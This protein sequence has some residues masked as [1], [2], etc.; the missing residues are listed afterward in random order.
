[1]VEDSDADAV[2]GQEVRRH[3]EESLLGE[4]MPRQG[5]SEAAG[6]VAEF[7]ALGLMDV[8]ITEVEQVFVCFPCFIARR[9]VT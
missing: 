4:L 3:E 2:A 7:W 1:M 5:L 9:E 8:V 6:C